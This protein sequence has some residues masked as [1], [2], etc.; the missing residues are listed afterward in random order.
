MK[1]FLRSLSFA[2]ICVLSINSIEAQDP[3]FNQYYTFASQLN[4]A[5]VGNYNGSYRLAVLYRQQWTSALGQSNGFRSVGAD[6]DVSLL[7]GYLKHSKLAVGVGFLDDRSGTAGLDYLN[8][9]ISLSYHQG[10]GKDG[11]H[12]LSVGLQGGY[13]QKR[14]DNPVFSDQFVSHDQT[15]I[16]SREQYT[17]GIQNG[18]FNAG[19]YWKSNFHDKIRFGVGVGLFHLIEPKEQ[20]ITASNDNFGKM[21][22]KFT[23]DFNLEAFIGKARKMSISPEFLFLTQGPAREITPGL[24]FSYYFQ[25]GFRKNNSMSIGLRYRVGDAVIPMAMAEF[26][27]IRLGFGYDVNV[28]GL[29]QTTK[30][31]GAFELSLSYVGESIKAF[32]GSRSLPSRRF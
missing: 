13:I 30:N 22:R 3:H 28:S 29:N 7:E 25:T 32:K 6:A 23:V 19:L 9:T 2:A 31:R 14:L 11:S 16:Q 12:R 4:P 10:F 17:R 1:N 15:L 24:F 21:Y 26:R 27:N 20:L 18:D 8:A 5:L